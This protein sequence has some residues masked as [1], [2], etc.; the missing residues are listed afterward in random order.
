MFCSKITQYVYIVY[1]VALACCS[2][3]GVMVAVLQQLHNDTLTVYIA[4]VSEVDGTIL[5]KVGAQDR[6]ILCQ[7]NIYEH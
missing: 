1:S 2:A 3:A 4:A 7:G 5:D 6:L